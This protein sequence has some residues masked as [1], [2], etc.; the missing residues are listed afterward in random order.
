LLRGLEI[1]ADKGPKS[2]RPH[3]LKA[4]K[5]FYQS[6]ILRMSVLAIV[7]FAMARWAQ[8]GHEL[9]VIRPSIRYTRGVMR[10]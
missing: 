9:R 6:Q 5:S 10:L 3:W 4:A 1:T 7:H 8:R 2:M